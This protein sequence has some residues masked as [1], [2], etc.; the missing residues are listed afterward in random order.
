[1]F[2]LSTGEEIPL[3][4]HRARI[5]QKIHL[6]PPQQRLEA[7]RKAG[8]N[9]FLMQGRDIFLDMLTDSGTN[10][11]SDR[12]LA[13]MQLADDSYAGSESFLR[14]CDKIMEI[15]HKPFVLPAHQGR[16]AENIICKTFIRNGNT[17]PMN[18]HFTTIRE[19]VELNGGRIIDVIGHEAFEPENACPFKGNCAVD[20]LEAI[21]RREGPSNIPFIRI[22]ACINLIGGQPVSLDNLR[23]VR[24]LA[25]T[26]GIF[27]VLDASILAENLY[28]IHRRECSDLTIREI[29]RQISALCD[30]I[31]FSARKLGCARGG[32]IITADEKLYNAMMPLVAIYEGFLTY[33]GMSMR[34]MEAITVGLDETMDLEMLCQAP[35]FIAY[36]VD[37]LQKRKVPVIVPPGGLGCHLDAVRFLTHVCQEEYPAGVLAA[38]IYLVSGIRSMERGTLSNGRDPKGRT[39]P[40]PLEL[41]RL[42]IPRRVFTLS[43]VKFA[44]DR[45]HWLFEN[46]HLI[47]GLEFTEGSQA[48]PFAIGKMQTIGRWEEA[49]L[50]KL[51]SDGVE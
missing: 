37:E 9:T 4:F 13:A 19:H 22:E 34:E 6:I 31:Y 41:V 21:I 23:K 32:A 11:M 39:I 1:M 36:M 48:L 8:F 16:A 14:F 45:I 15:F 44:I 47:G 28:F 17:V 26:F 20:H 42:A 5:V 33:G 46:R 51:Q 40:A 7:L 38:A 3:E 12:Q 18:Y 50:R 25:D 29:T 10:A 30:I 35:A 49:L 24:T 2:R 27:L 43:Q